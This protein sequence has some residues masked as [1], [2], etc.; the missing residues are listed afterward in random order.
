MMTVS[1]LFEQPCNKSDSSVSLL[2]VVNSFF[3]ICFCNL[4]QAMQTQIVMSLQTDLLQFVGRFVTICM[5]ASLLPYH[6]YM[7]NFLIPSHFLLVAVQL[8]ILY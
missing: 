3:A 7:F 2:Q 1:G 4:Q 8:K 5:L 6:F